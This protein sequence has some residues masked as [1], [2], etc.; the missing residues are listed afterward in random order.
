MWKIF[1][2]KC[3]AV[4]D[5]S[6]GGEPRGGWANLHLWAE[7]E[8]QVGGGGW[9]L[10]VVCGHFGIPRN[11]VSCLSDFESLHVFC[12]LTAFARRRE[13]WHVCVVA[14][15]HLLLNCEGCLLNITQHYPMGLFVSSFWPPWNSV[16]N[17]IAGKSM[18]SFTWEKWPRGVPLSCHPGGS[19]RAVPT[20]VEDMSPKGLNHD[21]AVLIILSWTF[22]KHVFL[23]YLLARI[24]M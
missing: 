15:T 8:E 2:F 22:I 20:R 13:I 7:T 6:H 12:F 4:R 5:P 24:E 11:G 10:R 21:P 16:T 9:V 14:I 19:L 17:Y 18:L 23:N 1:F 3:T